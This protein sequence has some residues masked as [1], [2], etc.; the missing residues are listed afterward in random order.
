MPMSLA[1]SPTDPTALFAATKTLGVVSVRL[2]PGGK[3]T[4]AGS[5]WAGADHGPSHIAVHG[6]GR[7]LCVAN[8]TAKSDPGVAI[9]PI[10]AHGIAS[11][12][13]CVAPH[14]WAEVWST[15]PRHRQSKPNPHG[16][17]WD[18]NQQFLH[19]ADLGLNAIVSYQFDTKSGQLSR[20][21][22]SVLHD[23]AGP[24]HLEVSADSRRLYTINECDSTVSAFAYDFTTGGTRHLLTLPSVPPEWL[25]ERRELGLE[26]GYASEIAVS[27][28]S[29]FV[30]CSNRGHD[31]IAIFSTD[32]D[33]AGCADAALSFVTTVPS[34]GAVPWGFS[35]AQGGTLLVAQNQ[36]AKSPEEGEGHI[37]SLGG[38]GN[39][40]VFRRDQRSGLLEPT[41]TVVSDLD[42]SIGVVAKL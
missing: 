13:V 29:R 4:V 28:D 15:D 19:C 14:P 35:L 26:M 17:C 8:C 22:G 9:L 2:G 1:L 7:W 33:A 34:G 41:G 10:G 6:S 38:S 5:A 21:S 16:C 23:G 3:P 42:M 30:Y 11:S 40:V 18:P 32:A 31:S 36:Y 24:R 37:S 25:Q 27:A 12:P 20:V 39:L